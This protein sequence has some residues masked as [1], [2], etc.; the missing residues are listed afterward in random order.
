PR[1]DERAQARDFRTRASDVSDEGGREPR[2][3]RPREVRARAA[4]RLR[5]PR[6]ARRAADA[7]LD[8]SARR[9]PAADRDRARRPRLRI[10]GQVAAADRRE[11]GARG[12]EPRRV[13]EAAVRALVGRRDAARVVRSAAQHEVERFARLRDDARL[14]D[15]PQAARADDE[16]GPRR[17]VRRTEDRERS[18]R[19]G[20][21]ARRLVEGVFAEADPGR[22]H[23][24]AVGGARIL[25]SAAS[26]ARPV[27]LLERTSGNNAK[28]SLAEH[29]ISV[30][31]DS[32]LAALFGELLRPRRRDQDLLIS[33]GTVWS[34]DAVPDRYR[35]LAADAGI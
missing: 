2:R 35:R 4:R 12:A 7:L 32:I 15:R 11:R 17:P 26:S 14:L 34:D 22:R 5:R 19:S 18:V 10:A 27:S 16:R 9:G 3:R 6:S 25:A 23:R 33:A 8:R 31:R 1:L 13:G 24:L 21:R 20:H 29:L 30:R 28:R